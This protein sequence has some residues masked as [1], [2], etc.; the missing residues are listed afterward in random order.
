MFCT[1]ECELDH[2]HVSLSTLHIVCA[3]QLVLMFVTQLRE[4]LH[5]GSRGSINNSEI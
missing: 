2:G 5:G 1:A 3:Q 4:V